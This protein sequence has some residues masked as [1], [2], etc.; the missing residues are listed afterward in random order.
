M[1]STAAACAAAS[2]SGSMPVMRPSPGTGG[3][4][5]ERVVVD[6][7][8][9]ERAGARPHAEGRI[10][11]RRGLVGDEAHDPA[12]GEGGGFRGPDGR[13]DLGERVC[14][15]H[16]ARGAEG[17]RTPARRVELE[18]GVCREPAHWEDCRRSSTSAAREAS[19]CPTTRRITPAARSPPGMPARASNQSASS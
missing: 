7:E 1:V 11:G 19:G 4:R 5:R 16:P 6:A 13:D 9:R 14:L 8:P 17:E 10:E 15:D 18:E 12:P 3:N 2:S